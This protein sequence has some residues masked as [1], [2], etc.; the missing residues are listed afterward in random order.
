MS[1]VPELRPYQM[2]AIDA[3][4]REVAAGHRR[5]LLVAPTGSGKT[6]IAA[7][8]VAGATAKGRKTLFLAHLR[9]LVRQAAGK[10]E[11]AGQD[12]GVIMAGRLPRPEAPVQVA[13]TWS[14]HGRAIR[15]ASEELPDADVVV[16]DE[17]HHAPGRVYSEII[18]KYPKAVI[19]GLSATP[20]RSDGRG[21]GWIFETLVECPSVKELTDARF[22][23]PARIFAPPPPDLTSVR[24]RRG[25]YVEADLERAMNQQPLVGDAVV[26]W[27]RHNSQRQPTVVFGVS[28]KHSI[29]LRDA[30]ARADVV[31]EHIDAATPQD[32][33]EAILDRLADGRVEVLCNCGV[34]LEGWDS[35]TVACLV[36][37]R[38]TKSL[39]LYRQMVGRVLRAAPGKTEAL[40][41]DHAGGCYMH[42]LPDDPI[43]WSLSA[44]RKAQNKV[45]AARGAGGT[46]PAL[47]SCPECHAV[48]WQGKPCTVCGWRPRPR[49]DAPEVVDGDLYGVERWK[50]AQK[51]EPTPADK[52]AFQGQLLTIC[53][54][55]GHS[56]GWVAHKFRE[57]FGHFPASNSVPAIE[58]SPEVL[59]WVKSRQI[60]YA[61]AQ[62]KAG[63]A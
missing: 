10:L 28:V 9:E 4:R 7:G 21:L 19:L 31:A 59:S 44:D 18:A 54:R 30:F 8:I 3:L 42:G 2:E 62:A 29:A 11:A 52:R 46:T 49:G 13:S 34:L 36:L 26:Q 15:S 17:A 37:A 43:E 23:V 1:A 22:L 56:A 38:P 51:K 12:V 39:A 57:K 50:G 5:V 45:H 40:I 47:V 58:P 60:A 32:E 33:R 14:L 20:C 35:P 53:H 61:K 41:L 63:A 6:L 55:R 24:T 25:E 48:R 27:H 16:V